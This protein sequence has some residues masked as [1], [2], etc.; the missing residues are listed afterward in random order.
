MKVTIISNYWKGSQG[1]GVKTYLVNFMDE[2][3]K[4]YIEVN[5]VFREGHD[6]ENYRCTGSRFLF[7]LKAF[8]N[9]RKIKP[10]IIHS[11]GAW[12]C[13]LPGVIYKEFHGSV[14]I[15]TFHTEPDKKLPLFFKIVFQG[16]LNK[17]DYVT[18]VSKGLEEKVEDVYGLKFKK[19][20]ITY[21]GVRSKKVSENE[22]KE[23]YEKF[24]LRNDS[25]ILLVQAFTAHK[26]KAEG[27]KLVIKAVKK[28]KE[29]YPNII[30][31]LTREGVYSNKLKE[32]SKNESVGNN[33]IF[34]GGVDNPFIPLAICDIY[35]HITLGEGGVSLALLEA[36]SM[37]KPIIATSVGGIPEA[38][39]D[40][41][42]GILIE[43]DVDEIIE[44][45]ECLLENR[46]FAEEL[47]ENAKKT[48]EE[49]FTWEKTINK[50][51]EIYSKIY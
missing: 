17:C 41:R 8:V 26:L 29:Q 51:V 10:P 34:T 32:F 28:L 13:L 2:L 33:V 40:G 7:P 11:H 12:Y 42:N 16:L 25:I 21:A 44:K 3:K 31:I 15:H 24:N 19:I 20:A 22:I 5:I 6:P 14:L 46:E 39:E 47:G 37:G 30:L 45:I 18:F 50:F 23:F 27:A 36:M 4:R 43:P 48:A 49:K 9:L 35:T 38:I 1:G